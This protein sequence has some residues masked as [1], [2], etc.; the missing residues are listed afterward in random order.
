MSRLQDFVAT[1]LWDKK[2][3]SMYLGWGAGWALV[4]I[5]AMM[6]AWH[7]GW[8]PMIPMGLCR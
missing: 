5:A 7:F 3:F 2:M 4:A 8:L 1:W 6:V